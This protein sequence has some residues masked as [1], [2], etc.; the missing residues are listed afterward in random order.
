MPQDCVV[1][2]K[3]ANFHCRDCF[4]FTGD[5]GSDHSGNFCQA[6]SATS[7][8]H[9]KRSGHKP[10]PIAVPKEICQFYAEHSDMAIEH[11]EMELFAVVCIETS[12]YVAFVKCKDDWCFFDSMADR[13]GEFIYNSSVLF[14]GSGDLD[15]V[16][17][18]YIWLVAG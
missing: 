6:C 18:W 16:A 10:Q 7:H 13:I 5:S 14:I 1:C 15:M 2:G 9:A 4:N 3:L 8:R 11:Q 12:H 17:W